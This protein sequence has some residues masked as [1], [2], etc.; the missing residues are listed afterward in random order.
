MKM[1]LE[2]SSDLV[3]EMKLKAAHEGRKLRDVADEILRRGLRQPA[4]PVAPAK[5][6]IKKLPLIECAHPAAAGTGLNPR[7]VAEVLIAQEAE[8]AREPA[9]R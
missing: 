4:P 5:R 3:R 8:W 1:T 2:L 9:R 6:R 7:R